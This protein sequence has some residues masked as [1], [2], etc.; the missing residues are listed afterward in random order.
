[1]TRL[2]PNFLSRIAKLEQ[3]H[4][5]RQPILSSEDRKYLI[6]RAVMGDAEALQKLN[7]N[8]PRITGASPQ[9]RAAALAAGLR[10]DL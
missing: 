8:R 5:R 9:Q 7:L 4:R 6:D 3:R 10:A 1:M 2:K